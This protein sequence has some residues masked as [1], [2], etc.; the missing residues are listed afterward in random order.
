MKTPIIML[1]DTALLPPFPEPMKQELD[2]AA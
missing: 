2:S 1:T